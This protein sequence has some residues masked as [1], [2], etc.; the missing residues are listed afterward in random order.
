MGKWF[1]TFTIFNGDMRFIYIGPIMIIIERRDTIWFVASFIPK[2][3]EVG[4]D[5]EIWESLW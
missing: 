3:I 2:S 4:W 1:S 5:K